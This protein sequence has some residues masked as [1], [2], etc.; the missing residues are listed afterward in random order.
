MLRYFFIGFAFLV[1][2]VV[3]MAGFRGQKSTRPPI[4][5]FPDM[6][7][8][9]KVK[10]QVPSSFFADGRGARQPI[11]DTVPMGYSI[12][13]HK[14]VDG[15]TGAA[16]GPYRNIQFSTSPDYY[17]TGKMGDQF[18]TGIPMEVTTALLERGQ[19]RYN[20]NCAVCHGATGEGNGITSKYGLVAIAN[21]QQKR[22]R[23]LADGDIF[24]TISHGKNTMMAYGANIQVPDRWA[25]VAYI[26]A[27]QH[28][29]GATIN[30]VPAE[31]RAKLEAP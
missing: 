24:N 13:M 17:N 14:A 25:I 15:N 21:F 27:L 22:L 28:A 20:I 29:Q 26:R 9:P 19:K 3:A 4:E 23:D 2:L 8:Q 11:A 18:G 31:E 10:A 6:D 5:L 16:G 1:L 7:H 12:P 30:D